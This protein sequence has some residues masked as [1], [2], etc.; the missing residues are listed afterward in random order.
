MERMLELVSKVCL[1]C[2][3]PWVQNVVEAVH[4][5]HL[6]RLILL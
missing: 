5:R 2:S 1:L 6:T 3:F 4:A